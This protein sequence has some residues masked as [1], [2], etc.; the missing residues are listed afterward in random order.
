LNIKSNL[1]DFVR[2]VQH[3]CYDIWLFY[4]IL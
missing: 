2:Q 4:F 1:F 3:I